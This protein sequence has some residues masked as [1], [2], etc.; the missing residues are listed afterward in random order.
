MVCTLDRAT[1]PIPARLSINSPPVWLMVTLL[2]VAG[3]LV[4]NATDWPSIVLVAPKV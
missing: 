3:R 2:T 4:I 1:L